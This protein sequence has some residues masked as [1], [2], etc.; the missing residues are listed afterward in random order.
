MEWIT[1]LGSPLHLYFVDCF[2]ELYFESCVDLAHTLMACL[3]RA[4]AERKRHIIF[5][6]LKHPDG[7]D[8][9]VKG[10]SSVFLEKSRD[11]VK[12]AKSHVFFHLG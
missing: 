10:G 6:K 3:C 2:R 7:G 8:D 4:G 9:L 5:A 1:R 11:P 12:T